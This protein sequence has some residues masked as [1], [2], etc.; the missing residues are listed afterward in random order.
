MLHVATDPK[1]MDKP[2]WKLHRLTTGYW[3]IWVNGNWRLTFFFEGEDAE[4]VDYQD[5]HYEI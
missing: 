2:G 1:E 4:I 3:S 5:Y